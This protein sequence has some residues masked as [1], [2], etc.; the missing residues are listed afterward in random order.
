MVTSRSVPQQTEQIV[1]LFAGQNLL[2][3]RFSQIGQAKSVV[4]RDDG[5]GRRARS[6]INIMAYFQVRAVAGRAFPKNFLTVVRTWQKV[7]VRAT[8]HLNG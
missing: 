4:S 6:R 5:S 1:S 3:G 7:E 2:G 8:E